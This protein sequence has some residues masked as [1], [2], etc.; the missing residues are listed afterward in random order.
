MSDLIA[1]YDQA[2]AQGE[3]RVDD[4]Q[5]AALMPL[6][7]LGT[8]LKT[9]TGLLW[10][11]IHRWRP[12]KGVYLYGSVGVGKTY[13]MDLFY[14]NLSERRKA[15][16][17][18]HQFM[19]QVDMQLRALQGTANPLQKIARKLAQTTR[20]LCFDEFLVND[21]A[22]AMILCQL[23]QAM[24]TE[25]I[26]L[27][28]TSN[29]RPDDLYLNGVQRQRFLPAIALINERCTVLHLTQH[30]DYRLGRTPQIAAWIYPLGTSTQQLMLSQFK[31]LAPHAA[32]PGSITVQ[33]R[34]IPYE[35]MGADAIWFSFTTI[36]NLPRSQLDYLELARRFRTL[37]VSE[38]PVLSE[39][40]TVAAILLIH[41]V[42]VLYDQGVRL[43]ISAA[44]TVNELYVAGEML[45]T[46]RRTRSRLEEMQSAD[47]LARHP[48]HEVEKI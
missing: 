36:C 35:Y 18:F 42:D 40:D 4:S 9:E 10:S 25:G 21:V 13:I 16:F 32:G 31:I 46:F 48:Y 15:R 6:E 7:K 38:V 37:F 24:M 47:Y 23:L 29:I 26:V 19:Q 2:V 39:H 22:H 28:A 14:H 20:V 8:Q 3:I 33:N 5:R 41:L 30:K 27:V 45:S 11:V 34:P 1:V 17:H 43:V 12:I 44:V